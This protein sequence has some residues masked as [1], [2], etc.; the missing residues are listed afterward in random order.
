MCFNLGGV[1]ERACE[2]EHGAKPRNRDIVRGPSSCKPGARPIAND[3][4]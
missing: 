2:G 3:S 4:A 1:S